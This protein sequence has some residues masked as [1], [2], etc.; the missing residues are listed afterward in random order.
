MTGQVNAVDGTDV[1]VV[2]VG[3]G[4]AALVAA[5]S[6]HENGAR[7]LVLEAAP[8]E[9]RGGNSRFTGGIFRIAHDGMESL[10]PL[11]TEESAKWKDRVDLDPYTVETY[12]DEYARVSR[13]RNSDV[14]TSAVIEESYE[15]VSWMVE[16]GV[17]FELA[18]GKLID[19]EKIDEGQ[20]Y[21]LPPGGA[22]RAADEG[23]G[24]IEDLFHAVE[25]AGIEVWY[26]A[27]VSELIMEGSTCTGVKVQRQDSHQEVRGNVV[28]ASGGFEANP[29]MRQKWLG[30]GWDL[31]KVRG[32]RFNT[33]AGLAAAMNAGAKAV[34]H[35]GGCH[36]VPLDANAPDVGDLKVT[37]KMSRY[38]YPFALLINAEG[39]RFV[40]EGE[41]HVWLTYAKTG[42]SVRAQTGA[43]AFQLFDS[44][45]THLLE[46]RY[47]T[48]TP[49]VADTLSELAAKLGV[50][51]EAVERT[52]HDY[53]AACSDGEFD[54]FG[55]DGLSAKPSGQ[56]AKS[57]WAQRIDQGPYTAYTVTCGITFTYGGIAVDEQARA[58]DFAGR[59]MPGLFATGEVTGGFFYHNYPAGAGLVRG[60]V[61]G[62]KAGRHAALA[63]K[64]QS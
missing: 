23:I 55:R 40:D 47:S 45:T 57:N 18:V 49:I 8:W 24:L 59:V 56:P 52:V 25:E 54:P 50:P 20:R 17:K 7:V 37:D 62:R 21:R 34:G 33:G 51:A 31:V 11:I 16:K 28:L 32:T 43:W 4:N 5:L 12:S 30:P 46:P 36:A 19:P 22:F 63:G 1:D 13:G 3:A 42:K 53:N 6:A 44:K 38:S 15:T 48:G 64:A 9:E 14:L 27:P 60:A 61:F 58:V 39:Q 29:Q 41:D 35:W 26:D 2:I 10:L